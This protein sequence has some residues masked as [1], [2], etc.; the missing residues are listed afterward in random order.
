MSEEFSYYVDETGQ[1]RFQVFKVYAEYFTL[2][3]DR[4]LEVLIQLQDW[5]QIEMDKL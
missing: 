5:I 1:L 2:E 4:R 3:S